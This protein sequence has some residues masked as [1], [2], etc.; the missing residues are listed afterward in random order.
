MEQLTIQPGNPGGP[1]ARRL[2]EELDSYLNSLYPAES[3][4]LLSVEA[5]QQPNVTFLIARI[6]G[7]P[8]GCGAFVNH[9]KYA[10]IKRMFVPPDLRGK[11]IGRRIMDELETHARLDGLPI[12]RLETGVSQPAALKLYEHCG[13]RRRWSRRV[14]W[15][16]TYSNTSD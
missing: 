8:V 5:L 14:F 1:D 15:W 11:G 12:S 9:G 2:I 10:E 13:N 7:K 16:K 6:N 4:H 3:N